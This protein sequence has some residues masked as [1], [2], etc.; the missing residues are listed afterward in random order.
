MVIPREFY[1][2]NTIEVARGLL[3]AVLMRRT[4]E[5]ITSGIITE[6][7]AYMGE[8]DPAAH[9]YKGKRDRVR[10]QYGADGHAYV[11][12]I[13]GLHH[14]FN[15]TTGPESTP[16]SVLIRALRPLDGIPVME[17]RRRRTKEDELCSGPGKLCSAMA[18]TM[19]QYGCDLTDPESGLW[20]EYGRPPKKIIAAPRV[21]ID[22]AGEAASWLWRFVSDEK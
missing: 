11:Y 1:E 7:E 21:G 16:E 12:L 14:C 2:G 3:G 17:R 15:I 18:I 20:L 5:G 4:E 13:Y 10:V 19:E 8:V 22:Y 9:S 6:C